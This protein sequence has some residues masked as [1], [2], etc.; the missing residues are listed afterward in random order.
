MVRR[1]AGLIVAVLSVLAIGASPVSAG[2]SP[3]YLALG[4]SLAAGYQPDPRYGRD[5]GYV[6]RVHRGL[7][8]RRSPTLRNLGCDGATTT[9][10]LSG[11][12]CTYGGADSQLAAA[13]LLLRRHPHR[14]RLVTIDIGANDVNRCVTGGVIDQ[15]CVLTAIGT[16]AGNLGEIVRR[17]RA[18]APRV[19]IIGMTYYNPYHAAWLRGPAGEAVARQSLQLATLLNQVLTGVYTGAGVRVADVA[20]AFA[21]EDL[22]TTA[23]LPDGRTVPLAVARICTWTWMCAPGRP[24]DIHA[25]SAGYEVIAQAF[26][27]EV[28]H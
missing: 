2:A 19:R 13:E 1:I 9:T 16:V 4:D 18:A 6:P 26:L 25:T 23:T 5:E 17:L 3:Y 21:T 12:G 27:A 10:L 28:R 14:V 22:T 20:G 15:P 24:S 8:G 7:S 11:G